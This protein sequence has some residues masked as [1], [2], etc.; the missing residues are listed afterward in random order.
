MPVIDL[1]PDEKERVTRII[2]LR[3]RP[4]KLHRKAVILY[5]LSRGD[6]IREIARSCRVKE[7]TLVG[8]LN[9]FRSKGLEATIAIA[10]GAAEHRERLK[11]VEHRAPG[12]E[13]F[14]AMLGRFPAPDRWLDDDD[15]WVL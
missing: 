3:P 11:G 1:T 7:E 5:Q 13:K 6:D 14:R 8:V 9:E 10:D 12:R 15:D 2:F 4:A